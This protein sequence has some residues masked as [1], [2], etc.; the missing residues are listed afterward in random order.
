MPLRLYLATAPE[1]L[2]NASLYTS[3]IA[4]AAYRVGEDGA[5]CGKALPPTLRGGLMILQLSS[6]LPHRTDSLCRQILRQCLERNYAGI[7]L[8]LTRDPDQQLLVFIEKLTQLAKA[9]RRRLYAPECCGAVTDTVV[10]LSTAISGGSLQQRLEQ[11]SAQ[12]GAPR[13]AL[14]LQRLAV[15]FTL[16]APQ[17]EGIPLSA[18]ELRRKMGGHTTYFSEPLCARYFTYRQNG[19]TH[20]V[21]FDDAATLQRKI[22]LAQA[23]GIG[24]GLLLFDE[25]SD[26]LPQLYG[27]KERS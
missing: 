18:E 27:E 13:I 6:P 16:P 14:D 3:H 23:L 10:L 2:G 9:Y 7:V 15:D 19:Q 12:Y 22:A 26:I 17:G 8:D 5:L 4:H 20:F 24:E 1:Q 11:A 21:L 25:V